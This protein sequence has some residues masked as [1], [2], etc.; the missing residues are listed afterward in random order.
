MSNIGKIISG[1]ELDEIRKRGLEKLYP[2]K[3][4]ISVGMASCGL[5]TGAGK[6]FAALAERIKQNKE[7]IILSTCGCLG[8][9]QKEPLLSVYTPGKAKLIYSQIPLEAVDDFLCSILAGKQ[10]QEWILCRIDDEELIIN[11]TRK[12]LSLNGNDEQMQPIPPYE[13]VPFF[14]RQKKI[15]LRNCGFIDSSDIDEYIGRGGYSSLLHV[16]T[17]MRPEEVIDEIKL[18][19]LRGRGGAGF[20]TGLKWDFCKKAKERPKY[21]ICNADEGDPGAYMDRSVLEG[22]PHSVLEGMLIGA[23][24]IGAQ[25]GVIYVRTEYPLAI[26]KLKQAVAQASD[27]RL[28]GENIFNK[29]FNF[30][31]RIVEGAGAFVCG[32]ETALIASVEGRPPEPKPRPPFPAQSGLWGK[33]TN[34]NNVETWA[35]VPVII[36]RG[37]KWFSGIGTEKSKG[38]KVFSLVGAVNNT[39]LV[40]VPMGTK[41][42]EI[43]YDMGGGIPGGKRLKAIQTGGPSGGCI[44]SNLVDMPV[45]YEELTKVGSIMGS[46]GMVVMDEENCMVD[47]ARYFTSFMRDESC[48]KCTSCRDGLDVALQILTKITKGQGEACDLQFLQELSEAIKDASECGLGTTAPNP[49]LSTI[50]YFR[51]EYEKHIKDKK[52]PAGV[53]KSLFE[54]AISEEQ[55][56]ACGKCK[57][58]CPVD[59]IEGEKKVAHKII[60]ARCTKCGAC[61]QI[62]PFNAV[63]KV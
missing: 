13:E 35:N 28:L 42:S 24:A 4:K 38:T 27:Y 1:K 10:K 51:D 49:V 44:P 61:Y 39:G 2:A 20:P 32:E 59:A 30:N 23:F 5:A 8:F 18:S 53:C 34:F 50:V 33:P 48:G 3:T 26:K 43:V 60:I 62:C 11:N 7:D 57:E 41:L 25:Q 45:D 9:C 46:G 58:N 56:K 17:S 31:V 52:C 36:A 14:S 29:D 54:Y 15:V 12:K 19:G 6:V 22:D 63:T 21:V 47:I 40:E 55:C 37:G 16:L